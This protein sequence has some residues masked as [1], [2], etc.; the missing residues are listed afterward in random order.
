MKPRY[1]T[2]LMWSAL[3]ADALIWLVIAHRVLRY[4]VNHWGF[5]VR[6][7]AVVFVVQVTAAVVVRRGAPRTLV[8]SVIAAGV[9][10]AAG[11]WALVEWN[12]LVPY[13]LWLKRG[14]PASPR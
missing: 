1:T 4:P 9:L 5:D 13:E 12:V 6:W 3:G 10:A 14:M 8:A 2:A 7:L 11:S